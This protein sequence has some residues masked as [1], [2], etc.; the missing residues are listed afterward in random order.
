MVQAAMRLSRKSSPLANSAQMMRAFLAAIAT[1]ARLKP[2]R[3]MSAAAQRLKRS[4]RRASVI[5]A[6]R[7]PWINRV[8][9]YTSPRLVMRPRMTDAE[10]GEQAAHLINQ[11]AARLH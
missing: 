1:H 7:A 9:R 10:L 6:E 11:A 8:R 2:R 5:S 4:V 3:A